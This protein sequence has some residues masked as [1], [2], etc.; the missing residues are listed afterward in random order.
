M[1]SQMRRS[2]KWFLKMMKKIS[3]TS[4]VGSSVLLGKDEYILLAKERPLQYSQFCI[5]HK[6]QAQAS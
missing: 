5:T 3:R 2:H 4:V 6:L 1:V